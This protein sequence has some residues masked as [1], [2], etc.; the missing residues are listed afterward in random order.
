MQILVAIDVLS[1]CCYN[2]STD[3]SKER[4]I[5]FTIR[6]CVIV[7]L[8][9]KCYGLEEKDYEAEIDGKGSQNLQHDT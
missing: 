2:G 9:K 8:V 6:L 3:S 4:V 7:N 1:L 5:I